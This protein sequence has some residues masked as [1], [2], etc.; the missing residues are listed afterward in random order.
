MFIDWVP[1]VD[2]QTPVVPSTSWWASSQ[3]RWGTRPASPSQWPPAPAPRAPRRRTQSGLKRTK[4]LFLEVLQL[5]IGRLGVGK[6]ESLCLPVVPDLGLFTRGG[7]ETAA[8]GTK[9]RKKCTSSSQVALASYIGQLMHSLMHILDCSYVKQSR[10]AHWHCPHWGVV[11][12]LSI[13]W[14]A[15]HTSKVDRSD[16]G[17]AVD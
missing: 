12:Q 11:G 9:V 14:G 5:I 16:K 4:G 3:R 7:G 15:A 10:Y 17:T 1:E 6:I 8:A 2:C 13:F